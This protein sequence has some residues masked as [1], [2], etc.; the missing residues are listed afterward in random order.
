MAF[1]WDQFSLAVASTPVRFPELRVAHLA[2][3]I[4]ESNR[5]TSLLFQRAGNPTGM[6]WR[7][8]MEGFATRL[9]L[10]TPTEPQ[11]AEWC[12][13]QTP[14]AAV[15]G[16]WRFIGRNPYKGWEA[17]G[18]D[19]AGY[20][21]HLKNC[22]YATD[23]A[24]V[25]KVTN[26][27]AEAR[28]ILSRHAAVR[29]QSVTWLLIKAAASE[30]IAIQAM[31]GSTAIDTLENPGKAP[32]IRFLLQ[33]PNAR[34]FLVAEDLESTVQSANT[35]TDQFTATNVSEVRFGRSAQGVPQLLLGNA[36]S[37]IGRIETRSSQRLVALLRSLPDGVL[38]RGAVAG[39][40]G[41][42]HGS[43]D[44]IEKPAMQWVAGCPNQSSRNGAKITAIVMHY[45]T[46][47]NLDG[48]IS[49]FKNP[50]AKV[51]AH[52]IIGRDGRI[53]QMVRDSEKAWHCFGFNT[54]SIG[55]EHAAEDGDQ[56]TPEQDKASA[57]LVTWLVHEYGISLDRIVGHR[58]NPSTP[59]GT[60]CPGDLWPTVDHLERWVLE[61]VSASPG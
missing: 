22:N 19:P 24:Y 53:V 40:V 11:G 49:W 51:S 36:T 29:Q 56:L 58:W 35:L 59:G 41:A 30:R 1:T 5:G 23:P 47:R 38:F 16:Y 17:F 33:Y 39:Q 37:L 18:Q 6:K 45:T 21:Q 3:C 31:A 4:L 7:S 27:F 50:A 10:A 13:W 44:A 48:T 43:L 60:S 57:A 42:G 15:R 34:T 28:S 52:Y 14:D 12:A 55:I 32:L 2:Q 26:L 54:N 8:E 61:R 20:I 25:Q 9:V 46:S